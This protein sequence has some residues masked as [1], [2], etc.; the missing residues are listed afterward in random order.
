VF[1]FAFK[2]DISYTH[3]V[4]VKTLTLHEVF[5]H[6]L[7]SCPQFKAFIEYI[8]ISL[9]IIIHICFHTMDT[10]MVMIMYKQY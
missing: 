5:R 7:R 1:F 2:A 8:T 3:I 10:L 4:F 6:A 9:C